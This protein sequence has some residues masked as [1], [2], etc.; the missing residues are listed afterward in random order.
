MDNKCN[1]KNE[2][3]ID[4]YTSF[5]NLP[6]NNSTVKYASHCLESLLRPETPI[7]HL[8]IVRHLTAHIIVV[9]LSYH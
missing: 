3:P 2:N 6:T 4:Y 8:K 5:S 7:Y 1:K 9:I